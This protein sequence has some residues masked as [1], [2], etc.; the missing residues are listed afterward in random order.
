[1]APYIRAELPDVNINTGAQSINT[2]RAPIVQ[3][4]IACSCATGNSAHMHV[5]SCVRRKGIEGF[6]NFNCGYSTYVSQNV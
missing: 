4:N 1:M 6:L 3:P 2:E 5:Y